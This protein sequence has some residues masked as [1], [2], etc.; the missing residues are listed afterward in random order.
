[1]QHNYYVIYESTEH[2]HTCG[3][4]TKC[5]VH[6]NHIRT[7]EIKKTSIC[8]KCAEGSRRTNG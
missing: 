3:E 2:C 6:L 5:S 1:M 4:L 7:T 8:K